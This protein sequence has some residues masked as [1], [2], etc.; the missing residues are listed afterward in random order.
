MLANNF[1]TALLSSKFYNMRKRLL[2]VGIVSVLI[3][4]LVYVVWQAYDFSSDYNYATAKLDIKNGNIRIINVGI[5]KISSID[6]EI[7]KVSTRYGFKNIY[8]KKFTPQQTEKGIKDYND[9]INKYLSYRN[10]LNWKI[11]YQKE[12]DS[13]YKLARPVKNYE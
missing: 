9:L 4:S 13:L 6:K 5:P 2:M 7:E 10:G 1:L 3:I 12:V 11:K 8:I